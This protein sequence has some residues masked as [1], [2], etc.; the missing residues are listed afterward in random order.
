MRSSRIEMSYQLAM[1]AAK[2]AADRRMRKGKRT[3]WNKADY[4]CMCKTFEKLNPLK[5]STA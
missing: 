5:P 3:H 4:Q 1:S 2:D